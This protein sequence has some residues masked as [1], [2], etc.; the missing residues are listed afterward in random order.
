[1]IG[2]F[3]AETSQI[4]SSSCNMH[5]P[6]DKSPLCSRCRTN[7]VLLLNYKANYFPEDEQVSNFTQH[8]SDRDP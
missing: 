8:D 7:Q 5:N 6:I 1:M 4:S 2:T 3:L